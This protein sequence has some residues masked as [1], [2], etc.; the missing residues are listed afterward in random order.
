MSLTQ[1]VNDLVGN[2]VDSATNSASE[3]LTKSINN[4]SDKASESL[5]KSI[6]KASE[7]ATNAVNSATNKASESATN[8]VNSASES[9]S[10][11]LPSTKGGA[12]SLSKLIKEKKGILKRTNDSINEFHLSSIGETDKKHTRKYDKKKIKKSKKVRFMI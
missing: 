2:S 4:A 1:G 9:V 8:A 11:E 6:N 10:S 5:K 3:L 7:S 12:K